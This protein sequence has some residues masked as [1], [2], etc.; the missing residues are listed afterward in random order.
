MLVSQ[1]RTCGAGTRGGAGTMDGMGTTPSGLGMPRL[2]E[3]CERPT[4][5]RRVD[6]E[7]RTVAGDHNEADAG[8]GGVD[9]HKAARC[10]QWTSSVVGRTRRPWRSSGLRG[11]IVGVIPGGRL[12]RDMCGFTVSNPL[13]G[14]SSL[15][16]QILNS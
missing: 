7:F 5:A 16:T 10:L 6:Q 11:H 8:T 2:W 3:G 4:L 13:S 14:P 9:A 1:F 15:N 12:R